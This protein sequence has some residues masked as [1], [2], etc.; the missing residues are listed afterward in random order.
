[1]ASIENRSRFV[2]SVKGC[3]DLTQTFAYKREN[4]LKKYLLELKELGH[5]PKLKR[6]NDSFAIR[7]RNIGH[8]EQCLYPHSITSPLSPNPIDTTSISAST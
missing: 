4:P 6:T 1:M 2:V 3:V 7:V 5:K 8:A